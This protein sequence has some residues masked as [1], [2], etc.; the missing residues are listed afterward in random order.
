VLGVAVAAAKGLQRAQSRA[1]N[2]KGRR[3]RKRSKQ[4][5]GA[6]A[7]GLDHVSAIALPA[8]PTPQVAVAHR[9]PTVSMSADEWQ[10]RL[11]AMLLARAFSEE[12]LWLLSHARIEDASP[13]LI[14]FQRALAQLT[15][16]ELS[17][18]IQLMLE[19]NPEALT[20]A[21]AEFLRI[22]GVARNAV[23][24]PSRE[25]RPGTDVVRGAAERASHAPVPTPPGWYDDGQGQHRWWDGQRWTNHVQVT[26]YANPGAPRMPIA[27]GWYND[28]SGR[29]RW[30]DGL[31]WT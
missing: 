8:A 15:P 14:D 31:R 21:E 2:E 24:R 27:A 20:D 17:H 25:G 13:A 12:Q 30:W 11:R 22:F 16:H 26:R 6:G 28:G 23:G 4:K 1:D 5:P 7:T 9:E 29:M 3:T 10:Q 18:R 19:A